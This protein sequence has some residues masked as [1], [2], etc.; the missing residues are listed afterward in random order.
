[1]HLHFDEAILFLGILSQNSLAKKYEY[2][3]CKAIYLGIPCNS[4]NNSVFTDGY[5][6]S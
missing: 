1:M 6:L 2:T 3:P 4:K 5:S